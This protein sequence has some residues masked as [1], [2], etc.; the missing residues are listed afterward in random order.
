M[1]L[2][3]EIAFEKLFKESYSVLSNIAMNIVKDADLSEDV[4]QDVFMKLWNNK[5]TFQLKTSIKSYLH[6]AVINTSLNYLE[7]RKI[8]SIVDKEIIESFELHESQ[9]KKPSDEE[10]VRVLKK[11]VEQL[12]PKC[13]AIFSLSRFEGMKNNEIAEYLDL[14]PKTVENQI[15]IA[16][17]QLR[18]YL[19]PYLDK[20]LLIIITL[21]KINKFFWG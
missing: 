6:R 14:K 7:K 4:V 2:K 12:P 11:G 10:I 3:D 18:V 19:K 21:I 13:Q 15:G 1:N 17:A 16:L 20:I 8:L 5:D 9:D